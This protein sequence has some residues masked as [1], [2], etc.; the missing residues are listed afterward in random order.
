GALFPRPLLPRCTALLPLSCFA[1]RAVNAV[2]APGI[3]FAWGLALCLLPGFLFLAAVA[4]EN[5]SINDRSAHILRDG[6]LLGA[7]AG[8]PRF[9]READSGGAR[10]PVARM[11]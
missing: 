10:A 6:R 2:V 1:L 4:W 7:R 11:P 9:G 3:S 5:R 8:E